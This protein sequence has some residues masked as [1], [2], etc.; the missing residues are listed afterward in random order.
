MVTLLSCPRNHTWSIT[1]KPEF[2]TE[3][4]FFFSPHSHPIPVCFS[5]VLSQLEQVEDHY[6][7]ENSPC[8]LPLVPCV[9]PLNSPPGFQSPSCPTFT[10]RALFSAAPMSPSFPAK[11]VSLRSSMLPCSG[12]FDYRALVSGYFCPLRFYLNSITCVKSLTT[13]PF[14]PPSFLRTF[15]LYLTQAQT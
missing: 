6:I 1:Y 10:Y 14:R 9:K 4:F 12:T 8:P 13:P 5:D 7:M 2:G 3:F 11:P 15:N